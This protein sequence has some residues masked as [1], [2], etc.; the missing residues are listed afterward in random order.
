MILIFAIWNA[1][2][3]YLEFMTSGIIT[4]P[5]PLCGIR[6]SY[7]AS[8]GAT[9]SYPAKLDILSVAKNLYVDFF[10]CLLT[11]DDTGF[12]TDYRF[13]HLFILSVSIRGINICLLFFF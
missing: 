6:D 7:T 4:N 5:F 12:V 8:G 3:V 11:L 10:R 9:P 13:L 1:K 2:S